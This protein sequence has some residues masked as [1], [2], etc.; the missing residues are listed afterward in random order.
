MLVYPDMNR[1]LTWLALLSIS[2]S[3]ASAKPG[4]QSINSEFAPKPVVA[5]SRYVFEFWGSGNT[6]NVE[7]SKYA[8]LEK[9]LSRAKPA[10]FRQKM[11]FTIARAEI[12][13]CQRLDLRVC[14]V[15]SEPARGSAF[16]IE[17]GRLVT[18]SHNF[19]PE[20]ALIAFFRDLKK[21]WNDSL[22]TRDPQII[23]KVVDSIKA[24][25]A[26]PLKDAIFLVTDQEQNLVFSSLTKKYQIVN[27]RDSTSPKAVVD[28]GCSA[29]GD[30][31]SIK[32]ITF[33]SLSTAKPPAILSDYRLL[34]DDIAVLRHDSPQGIPLAHAP[35]VTDEQTFVV[36]YPAKTSNRKQN[37]FS[38]AGDREL[39]FTEGISIQ[40]NQLGQL[41]NWGGIR[42]FM[43]FFEG[44]K[45]L[46]SDADGW[47]G[48]SGGAILNRD[49]KVCGVYVGSSPMGGQLGINAQSKRFNLFSIGV[50]LVR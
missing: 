22:A 5:A 27:W 8:D 43:N 14:S 19:A 41:S 13:R 20:S 44:K 10:S 24:F 49:G 1:V 29:T 2:A 28:L 32:Q 7:R 9:K 38:D 11:A 31:C 39:V 48:M 23:A 34:L 3:Q 47:P 35:C 17:G 37:G 15:S 45:V 18:V 36:G 16:F 33:E 6:Q 12:A 46:F 25:S 26:N 30:A 50:P 21:S 42:V 4:F 40:T